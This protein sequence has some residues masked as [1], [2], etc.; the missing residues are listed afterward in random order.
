[1]TYNF[2][3]LSV[4]YRI[5]FKVVVLT[6]KSFYVMTPVYDTADLI[7]VKNNPRSLRSTAQFIL[8]DAK[9][10]LKTVVTC[11]SEELRHCLSM[12]F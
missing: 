2:H 8:D 10:S 3:E 4:F 11:S 5:Q 7:N 9:T 6:H 1:M 12:L